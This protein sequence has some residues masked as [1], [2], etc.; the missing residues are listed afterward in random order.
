MK[1]KTRMRELIVY[2]VIGL[3][4]LCIIF[5]YINSLILIHKVDKIE[6]Q[7]IE[8][9]HVCE[10]V[11]EVP[12]QQIATR[13]TEDIDTIIKNS[14]TVDKGE[15]LNNNFYNSLTAEEIN[16]IEV[17]VQH[18]VGD[19]SA[20]Y[21]KLIAEIIYNRIKS[22]E[23]PNTVEEVLFRQNQF[24]GINNWYSPDYPVDDVTKQVVKEVFSQEETSH[25]AVYYYNPDYSTQES[26]EWFE[27][28]GDVEYL[29]SHT[30]ISWG[31]AYESRFF[32]RKG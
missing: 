19:F 27:Y 16:M 23:F 29:F 20:E 9:T 17:T 14:E 32:G 28:S 21:K 30:E 5:T 13:I 7:I 22:E 11:V 10:V 4:G 8:E 2:C 12:T 15:K 1:T 6:P 25:N 31:I 3:I 24:T 26:I 18:E